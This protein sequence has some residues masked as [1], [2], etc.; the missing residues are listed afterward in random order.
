MRIREKPQAFK[1]FRLLKDDEIRLGSGGYRKAKAGDYVIDGFWT[2]LT[3]LQIKNS[4]DIFCECNSLPRLDYPCTEFI[5]PD[6]G[7]N[8]KNCCH[9]SECHEGAWK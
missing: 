2:V 4:Y 9:F 6:T 8:C 1:V 5:K 7:A 3:P